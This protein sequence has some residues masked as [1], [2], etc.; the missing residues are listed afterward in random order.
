MAK[1]KPNSKTVKKPASKTAS[2]VSK[3]NVSKI[4][5]KP[6]SK[7]TKNSKIVKNREREN[8]ANELKSLIPKLDEEGLAFLVKQAHVHLYNMQVEALNNTIIKDGQR[9]SSKSGKKDED[10]NDVKMSGS[11]YFIA[12]NS[13]WISFT[14]DE[15]AAVV[16]IA[17]GEGTEP[18]IT[19][20]LYNWFS[21][22]RG[23]VLITAAIA[24]KLDNKLITLIS[25]L[26]NNFRMK[27]QRDA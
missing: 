2:S 10:F 22:E 12:Y 8:L 23:D 18:E 6:A 26:K 27:N 20:R 1:Q 24:G 25:I 4:K 21:R 7:K 14:K 19:E 15:M 5:T 11:G 16:K 9:Q 3:K 17:L 13:D